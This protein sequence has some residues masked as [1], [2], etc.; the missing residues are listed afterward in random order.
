MS[1]LYRLFANILMLHMHAL[2]VMSFLENL[3]KTDNIMLRT[4]S[5][6]LSTDDVSRLALM[7]DSNLDIFKSNYRTIIRLNS[8]EL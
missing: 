4:L 7:F 6:N 2:K 5:S 1:A 3:N 8:D